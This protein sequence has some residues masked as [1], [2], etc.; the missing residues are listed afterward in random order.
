[1]KIHTTNYS[2][3]FIEIADDCPVTFGEIPPTK[4]DTKTVAGMQFDLVSKNPYK[5][6]S[7]DILF[8]V[9]AER[10][11]LIRSEYDEARQQFFSKGQ[12]C[13]RAS[14]LTKRYG[15]GVY[16]NKDGKIALYGCETEEYEKFSK[17]KA[18]KVIKAMK[19]SK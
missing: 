6:T 19:S 4:G 17:D 1:M 12:P 3:T 7:D 15:W 2:N 8:Q 14:P 5:F 16:S 10:N 9:Y 13:F 18:L 11:D